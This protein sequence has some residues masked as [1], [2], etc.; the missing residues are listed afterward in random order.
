MRACSRSFAE[1]VA[2]RAT[3][4]VTD[5]PPREFCPDAFPSKDDLPDI[6]GV[7]QDTQHRDAFIIC[8]IEQDVRR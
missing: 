5:A 6:P 1:D 4:A 2:I 7:M 3:A 8:Q